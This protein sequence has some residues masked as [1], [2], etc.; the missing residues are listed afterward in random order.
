M[1]RGVERFAARTPTLPPA[2][3]TQSYALGERDV[4]LV[5]PATPYEDEQRDWLAWTEGLV[6]SGRRLIGIFLT[7]HHADHVGGAAHFSQALGL[8]LFAHA[9]T[10]VR[11]PNLAIEKRFADGDVIDLEGPSVQRWKV[12][13]TPGHAPGH[14]CL[15]EET[16]KVVVVGD[17]VASEGTILVEPTDGDMAEYIRQ[18]ERLA[19]LEARIALP[20]HGDPIDAPTELFRYYVKHRLAREEKVFSALREAGEGGADA[21]SL[22]P[23]AYADTSPLAWP[24]ARMALEAHLIKLV[25]DGRAKRVE[26]RWTAWT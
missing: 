21:A 16:L 12:L 24:I 4:L 26:E 15:L 18:I 20:A 6:S 19:A 10:A 23:V 22:V 3:H 13:H 11:L 2:T 14:L 8:P 25:S 1:T 7:H 9:A 5:E 17:M